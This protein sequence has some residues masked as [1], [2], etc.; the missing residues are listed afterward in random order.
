MK[1]LRL[2][3]VPW[4]IATRTGQISSMAG[5]VASVATDGGWL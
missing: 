3:V 1:K 5:S 2:A 4:A